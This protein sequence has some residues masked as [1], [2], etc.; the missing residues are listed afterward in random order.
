ML[1]RVCSFLIDWTVSFQ[2]DL[3]KYW[4]RCHCS[5]TDVELWGM[6]KCVNSLAL[7]EWRKGWG[8]SRRLSRAKRESM[9]DAL[10][11]PGLAWD[12]GRRSPGSQ[13]HR[14]V[15]IWRFLWVIIVP[16]CWSSVS[17]VWG[18]T[19]FSVSS[20]WKFGSFQCLGKITVEVRPT[21]HKQLF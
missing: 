13:L 14:I 19:Q 6:R 9:A 20:K 12:Q 4:T 1:L 8:L 16:Q 18:S 5:A 11:C 21:L 15:Q 10:F 3:M 2:Q 17:P 7:C